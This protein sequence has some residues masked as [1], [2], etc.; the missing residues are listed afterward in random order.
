MREAV[1]PDRVTPPSTTEAFNNA[2]RSQVGRALPD[3]M[4]NRKTSRRAEPDLRTECEVTTRPAVR[5]LGDIESND[6]LSTKDFN[7]F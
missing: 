1:F 7:Y 4:G 2:P 6:W 3:M 5:A